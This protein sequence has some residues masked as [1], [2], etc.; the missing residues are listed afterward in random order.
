ML[1][2]SVWI[3]EKWVELALLVL[4][5]TLEVLPDDLFIYE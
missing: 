1:M 3:K 4:I 2:D 5:L